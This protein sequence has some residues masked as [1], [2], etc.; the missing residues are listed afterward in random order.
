MFIG[1][2]VD[3]GVPFDPLAEILRSLEL[4]QRFDVKLGRRQHHGLLGADFRVEV[5]PSESPARGSYQDIER[6]YRR[7]E[8]PEGALARAQQTL[9]A[10]AGAH[11][12]ISSAAELVGEQLIDTAVDVLG[13]ALALE[14]LSPAS[15]SCRPIPVGQG[16][17]HARSCQP[18]PS[19]LTLELLRGA[20]VWGGGDAMELCTPT[21]A[22]I[23][24]TT[25]DSYG[26]LPA[27]RLLGVGYGAGDMSLEDRP[28]HLRVILLA[29]Q[30]P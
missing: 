9:A 18:I 24:A 14:V 12:T 26:E 6:A 5:E 11:Q 22:A 15:V 2:M 16:P 1:A 17:P 3:L 8:L 25:V 10:L 20:P 21:G 28:N 29:P 4:P 30:E 19:P 7:L 13:A 23:A 27:G